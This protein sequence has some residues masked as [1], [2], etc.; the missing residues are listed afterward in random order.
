M[1]IIAMYLPQFHEVKENSEWWGKGFTEWT[2]VKNAKS[3]YEGHVQPIHP[4]NGNYYN[5]LDKHTMEWQSVLMKQYGIDG[6]CMYHY[7]FQ[8]GRK[9]LE[10][11]AENLLLWKEIDIP[12]CFSW[13]NETWA[14]TWHRGKNENVWASDYEKKDNS[15]DNGILLTQKYG[16]RQDWEKHFYYLLPFFRDD[17]YIKVDGKP[18]FVFYKVSLLP[19]FENMVDCWMELASK[20]GLSGLYLIGGACKDGSG[21]SLDEELVHEPASAIRF[22]KIKD[23]CAKVVDYDEIWKQ[24]LQKEPEKNKTAGGFV[25]YDTTPRHGCEGIIIDG[26][27]PEKF[28]NN[29]AKLLAKNELAGSPFTFINAW[30][31]WGEGMYLEPDEEHTYQY[32][33]AVLYAKQHYKELISTTENC[34]TVD[35]SE[36]QKRYKQMYLAYEKEAY[37]RDIIDKWMSLRDKGINLTDSL[38]RRIRTI[39]IYGY[40]VLGKHFLEETKKTDLSVKYI[41]DRKRMV[42]KIDIPHFFPDNDLPF[43][44]AVIVTAVYCYGEVYRLLKVKGVQNIISLEYLIHENT[45]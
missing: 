12:F 10:K 29:F 21:L 4:Y 26:G 33:E 36:W 14:R 41:I 8:N 19:C 27:N 15:S 6:I 39:A 45:N 9:I 42:E 3:L 30:N 38:D 44:D 23:C 35:Q 31:E 37:F 2:T 24:I 17:R 34:I 32:L 28:K 16:N 18:V 11:P 43:V 25:S 22:C 13:A 5:L 40:G 20:E 1:K 7:W